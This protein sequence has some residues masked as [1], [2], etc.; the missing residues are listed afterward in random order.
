[1]RFY[2][3]HVVDRPPLAPAPLP[4]FLFPEEHEEH[5]AEAMQVEACEAHAHSDEESL[6]A[7][8]IAA[9]AR[10]RAAEQVGS[11]KAAK[12]MPAVKKVGSAKADAKANAKPAASK[13]PKSKTGVIKPAKARR[14]APKASDHA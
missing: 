4:A 10:M 7:A 1:M 11:A 9:E 5:D 3:H 8:S 13:I 14:T 12:G 2:E 6:L